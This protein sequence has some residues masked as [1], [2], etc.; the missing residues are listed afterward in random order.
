MKSAG[1][2]SEMPLHSKMF[3]VEQE[4]PARA[5]RHE[6]VADAR[7]GAPRRRFVR[8]REPRGGDHAPLRARH[9]AAAVA[10]Y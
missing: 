8:Q 7:G 1:L 6:P 3:E 10:E 4:S 2:T 5:R 9:V